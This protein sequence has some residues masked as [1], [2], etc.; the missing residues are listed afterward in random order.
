MSCSL[1]TLNRV[2]VI[3]RVDQ[4]ESAVSVLS[5]HM[6]QEQRA[7]FRDKLYRYARKPD[8]DL[9]LA[10]AV[11]EILGFYSV[12]EE[13]DLPREVPA[14]VRQRLHSFACGT[15]LL[16]HPDYRQRGIGT[17]LQLFAEQWARARGK[18]GFW[19]S[20]RRQADWYRSHFGYEEAGRVLVKGVERRIMAKG[21]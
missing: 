20:T 4:V 5:G 16:V 6:N 17:E 15:G 9:I 18:A 21:F 12:I 3:A 19:L 11:K 2:L 14:A 8:R 1:P 10:M 7:K 13:D